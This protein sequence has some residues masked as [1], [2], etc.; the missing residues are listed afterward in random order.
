MSRIA[1]RTVHPR[2]KPA[3]RAHP[4]LS[5]AARNSLCF[6]LSSD[7]RGTRATVPSSWAS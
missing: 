7:P 6:I 2:R 4:Y 3:A 5:L 1:H